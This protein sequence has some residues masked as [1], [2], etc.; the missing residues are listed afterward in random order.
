M[1]VSLTN[2]NGTCDSHE[3]HV[4]K[5]GCRDIA[6][7]DPRGLYSWLV[8][9]KNDVVIDVLKEI[10][11]D[12]VEEATETT[13]FY[14]GPFTEDYVKIFNCAKLKIITK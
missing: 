6:K 3:F 2:T 1:K 12:F 14:A 10:N 4:H 9:I 11:S 7:S 5:E 13:P 8:E